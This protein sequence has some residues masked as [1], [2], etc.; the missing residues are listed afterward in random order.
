MRYTREM[1]ILEGMKRE[2]RTK[3]R[4]INIT[5]P[6]ETVKLIDRVSRKGGRS[7]FIDEAV[8]RH[9][10]EVGRA[11]LRR[12]LKAGYVQGAERDRRMI[13][14]WFFVDGEA[15]QRDAS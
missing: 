13:E 10:R 4:R 7:R 6:E 3:H 5:L 15:W 1:C 11:R 14:E 9:V 8:R 2:S 12:Q